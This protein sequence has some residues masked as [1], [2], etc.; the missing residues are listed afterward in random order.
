MNRLT[1]GGALLTLV[2]SGCT[3]ID[4]NGQEGLVYYEP[5]PYLFVS[6]T[7]QCISSVSVVSIPG[8]QK[9]IDFNSGFGSSNMSAEFSNGIITKVGQTSDSKIPAALASIA[10]LK[11]AGM[12]VEGQE[13]TC[14]PTARL[15]PIEN[16]VPRTN[17]PINFMIDR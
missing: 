17:D 11:T 12:L 14:E 8:V 3:S 16:G 7:D 1:Y 6:V 4:F 15:Y 13:P 5:K 2:L 9:N 10:A